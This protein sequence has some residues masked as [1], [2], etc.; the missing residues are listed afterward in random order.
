MQPDQT[1]NWLHVTNLFYPRKSLFSPHLFIP[2]RPKS[3]PFPTSSTFLKHLVLSLVQSQNALPPHPIMCPLPPG[4][5]PSPSK[6]SSSVDP[7]WWVSCLDA[8]AEALL[9]QHQEGPR[10]VVPSSTS[11]ICVP[12]YP[13]ASVLL[14]DCRDQAVVGWWLLWWPGN[15]QGRVFFGLPLLPL[16]LC[17]HLG[18][19]R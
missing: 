15:S 6:R 18:L 17:A 13:C 5:N 7:S 8:G 14:W 2:K 3:I 16:S 4:S 10:Q 9:G 19:C 11:L 1:A 12:A